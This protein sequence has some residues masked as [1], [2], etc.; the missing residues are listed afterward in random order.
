MVVNVASVCKLQSHAIKSYVNQVYEL[1][2]FFEKTARSLKSC[3]NISIAVR[4][5]RENGHAKCMSSDS[6]KYSLET[7]PMCPCV[8]HSLIIRLSL[9]FYEWYSNMNLYN[10]RQGSTTNASSLI[11]M[12][13]LVVRTRDVNGCCC[14]HDRTVRMRKCACVRRGACWRVTGRFGGGLGGRGYSWSIC[15]SATQWSVGCEHGRLCFRNCAARLYAGLS[16]LATQYRRVS[17]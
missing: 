4:W 12:S 14:W 8:A 17:L 9:W 16:P 13:L 11:P 3:C 10:T 7:K 2:N 1:W 6:R 15:A 5:R